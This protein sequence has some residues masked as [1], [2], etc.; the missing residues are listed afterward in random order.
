MPAC[1]VFERGFGLIAVSLR[2]ENAAKFPA[3]SFNRAT[4]FRSDRSDAP[5]CNVFG[6]TVMP[7][8]LNPE[9]LLSEYFGP[10]AVPAWRLLPAIEAAT[11]NHAY[12]FMDL[13]IYNA[14]V[15]ENP[16]EAQA[17]YWREMLLR[18]HLACCISVRR[19]GEWLDALL[20]AVQAKS[21]FAACAAYRGFLESAADSL[22]SLGAGPRTLADNLTAIIHRLKKRRMD[23]IIASKEMEDRL[24]HFTH[25]RKLERSENP[26]PVHAA[27]QIREYLDS[28]KAVGVP[29]VHALYAELCSI[30]HPAAESVLIWFEG[31][32][33]DDAVIW[34]R[35]ATPPGEQIAGLLAHWKKTNDGVMNAA[36]VPA[37]MCLRI[38][39]KV[40][41]LPKIP[42]LRSFPLKNFPGWQQ[43][44]RQIRK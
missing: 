31:A 16:E 36:F 34:R 17:V 30:T 33:E 7:A 40:D 32:K 13:D 44:E 15:R 11:K 24:I 39:H 37:F 29:D 18:I 3:A 21:L 9:A 26:D 22:Y 2:L 8:E 20:A 4:S 19:H 35:S 23:T 28:L 27:R 41:F 43:I 14:L 1:S 42:S 38:L 5:G 6:G 10:F 12:A 25:G